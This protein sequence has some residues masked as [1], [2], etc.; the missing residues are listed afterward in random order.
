MRGCGLGSFTRKSSDEVSI[1]RNCN[2]AGVD[3][4]QLEHN[5]TLALGAYLSC[6]RKNAGRKTVRLRNLLAVFPKDKIR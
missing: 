5:L 1:L 4:E 6:R 2:D 3:R